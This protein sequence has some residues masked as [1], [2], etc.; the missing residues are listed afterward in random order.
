MGSAS[1]GDVGLLSLGHYRLR[2]FDGPVE[3]FQVG[4]QGEVFPSV[5]AVPADHHNIV[6][7]RTSFVGR[8]EEVTTLAP[9]LAPGRLV[10]IGGAGGVDRATV[11]RICERLDGMPLAIELAASRG[12]VLSVAEIL[13]GLDHRF[14][15]LRSRDRTAPERQR[16]MTAL[17]DWSYDLLSSG[18]RRVFDRPPVFA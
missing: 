7:A 1:G 10:T 8:H 18:E 11:A 16:T 13:E 6:P 9:R 2:D 4:G 14:R 15:L 17:L 5:R 12:A 3:L